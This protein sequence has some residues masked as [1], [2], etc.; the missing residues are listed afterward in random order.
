M[1][2][3]RPSQS[4]ALPLPVWLQP[5]AAVLP[6]HIVVLLAII[7]AKGLWFSLEQRARK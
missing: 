2:V 6:H 4:V 5:F 3:R 7:N 1:S